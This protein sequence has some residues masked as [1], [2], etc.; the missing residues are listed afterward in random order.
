MKKKLY[1]FVCLFLTV[2]FSASAFPSNEDD[3]CSKISG[4]W[5]GKAEIKFFLFTCTY[6]SVAEI[7]SSSNV[8]PNTA[9][10]TFN[11]ASGVFLCPKNGS[12]N[13]DVSCTNGR[14]V[15]KDSKID[16]AGYLNDDGN[17]ATLEGNMYMLFRYHPFK[18]FVAKNS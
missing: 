7:S 17:A 12:H 13:V 4:T 2:M 10:V 6:D 15:M 1:L 14:V 11:K 9:A 16:V 3:A 5:L 18:L 8:A